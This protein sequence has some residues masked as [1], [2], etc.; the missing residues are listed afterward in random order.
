MSCS[1]HILTRQGFFVFSTLADIHPGQPRWEAF[2]QGI[3]G[4]GVHWEHPWPYSAAQK[5][6]WDKV[7]AR[8]VQSCKILM[9]SSCWVFC[10]THSSKQSM[11]AQSLSWKG[12]AAAWVETQ[13]WLWSVHQSSLHNV[14]VVPLTE[15][16]TCSCQ[17]T[18]WPKQLLSSQPSKCWGQRGEKQSLQPLFPI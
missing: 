10:C 12:L 16:T 4:F 5:Q 8:P 6:S 18:T 13:S 1:F 15:W 9:D 17:K 14:A 2:C 11:A 3:P 7:V